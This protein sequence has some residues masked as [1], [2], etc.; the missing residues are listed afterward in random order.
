MGAITTELNKTTKTLNE[1]RTTAGYIGERLDIVEQ[2]ILQLNDQHE[3]DLSE[4]NKARFALKSLD[5]G[6][7]QLVWEI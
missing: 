6:L 7:M 5:K 3:A 4:L 2:Y 1:L